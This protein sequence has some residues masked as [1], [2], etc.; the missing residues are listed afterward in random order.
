LR[1]EIRQALL[2]RLFI[3]SNVLLWNL[4]ISFKGY[5]ISANIIITILIGATQSI[6]LSS[7]AKNIY[8]Y[9]L[10]ILIYGF[11]ISFLNF[12]LQLLIRVVSSTILA[13]LILI[14]LINIEKLIKY[15][16]PIISKK[17]AFIIVYIIILFCLVEATY[18]FSSFSEL[19]KIASGGIYRE[20]SH[21][22][23]SIL[24]FFFLLLLTTKGKQLIHLILLIFLFLLVSLSSTFIVIFFLMLTFYF[25]IISFNNGLKIKNILFLLGL[26]LLIFLFIISPISQNTIKRVNES[27][28][29]DENSNISSLVYVNGWQLLFQNVKSSYGLGIG[30]NAMGFNSILRTSS[31][32]FLEVLDLDNL[33]LKDG[34][35]FF[36]KFISE[37]GILGFIMWFQLF[38]STLKIKFSKSIELNDSNR[39]ICFAFISIISIGG[40]V[41]SAVYFTGSGVLCMFFIIIIYNKTLKKKTKI[42][43]KY[44]NN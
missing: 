44:T 35:F 32:D 20:Q 22:A 33:G 17:D 42:E 25:I 37:F 8:F 19:D 39:I 6:N 12:Q 29:V 10:S 2:F 7:K 41:R 38:I 5:S 28:Y 18:K 4:D 23:L 43:T 1:T 24:P 16:I 14:S 36:S 27:I 15:D 30:F 21:T 31:M 3:F 13:L 11:L 40:F 34:S 26:I 9:I